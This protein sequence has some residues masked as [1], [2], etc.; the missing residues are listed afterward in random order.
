MFFTSSPVKVS[1][2]SSNAKVA[3]KRTAAN[4]WPVSADMSACQCPASAPLENRWEATV[5]SQAAG[6]ADTATTSSWPG[7][8]RTGGRSFAFLLRHSEDNPIKSRRSRCPFLALQKRSAESR[9][10][11]PSLALGWSH[12][13]ETTVNSGMLHLPHPA[14]R[15]RRT[16]QAGAHHEVNHADRP[17]G[18][19]LEFGAPGQFLPS[20]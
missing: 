16:Q 20:T 10:R 14:C 13:E 7:A 12:W 19:K 5:F 1:L 17:L 6:S 11:L 9:E 18:L 8:L 15:R 2:A 4:I 3:I